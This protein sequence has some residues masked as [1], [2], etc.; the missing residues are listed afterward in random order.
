MLRGTTGVNMWMQDGCKVYMNS[1]M[2]SNKSRYMVTRTVFNNHLLEVDLTPNQETV[3]HRTLTTVDSFYSIM[4]EGHAWIEIHWNI[5]RLR[6]RSHTALPYTRGS[7]T[8]L[9]DDFG[10]VLGR[11]FGHS[12]FWALTNPTVTALGS[13][14]KWPFWQNCGM[15]LDIWKRKNRK[16]ATME[17]VAVGNTR[18]LAQIVP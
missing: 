14:V 13:C 2:A 11:R 5:I 6:A 8:T 4:C 3:T 18:L 1:Y 7:V 12:F 17:A 16:I 9:H 15:N 10:G